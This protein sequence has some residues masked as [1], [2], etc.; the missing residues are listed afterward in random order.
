[1]CGKPLQMGYQLP[2][3]TGTNSHLKTKSDKRVCAVIFTSRG[4]ASR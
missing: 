2:N 1:M 4:K 3:R